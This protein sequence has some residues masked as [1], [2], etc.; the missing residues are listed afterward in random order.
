MSKINSSL[1]SLSLASTTANAAVWRD[2]FHPTVQFKEVTEANLTTYQYHLNRPDGST[3][4]L[5]IPSDGARTAVNLYPSVPANKGGL[6]GLAIDG[7]PIWSPLYQHHDNSTCCDAGLISAPLADECHCIVGR[8]YVKAPVCLIQDKLSNDTCHDEV[9]V[10]VALDG[11]KIKIGGARLTLDE[12]GGADNGDEY[13]YYFTDTYPYSLRCFKGTPMVPVGLEETPDL[14]NAQCPD[15]YEAMSGVN[16]LIQ[17]MKAANATEY[18]EAP[19][20]QRARSSTGGR[21][22][23]MINSIVD[24]VKSVSDLKIET[25]SFNDMLD[26]LTNRKRRSFNDLFKFDGTAESPESRMKDGDHDRGVLPYGVYQLFPL[27]KCGYNDAE[28]L[29][30]C[31][32]GA[33]H[34]CNPDTDSCLGFYGLYQKAV[35]CPGVLNQPVPLESNKFHYKKSDLIMAQRKGSRAN[36]KSTPLSISRTMMLDDDQDVTCHCRDVTGAKIGGTENKFKDIELSDMSNTDLALK[37][38]CLLCPANTI[39]TDR[40]FFYETCEN[41]GHTVYP[42]PIFF[43]ETVFRLALRLIV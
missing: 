7:K 31:N 28:C 39:Q 42:D 22:D 40:V 34:D 19:R 3:E 17:K 6:I 1:S 18:K 36:H 5:R 14:S 30:P 13:A 27:D 16:H 15:I 35:V 20:A 43:N 21:D 37:L 12:C 26:T 11:F 29:T 9:T 25:P 38:G 8:G 10:G 33:Y 2:A 32:N 23:D 41:P 4:H 24:F